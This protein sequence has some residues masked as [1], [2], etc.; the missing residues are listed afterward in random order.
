[1][2]FPFLGSL[3]L[4]QQTA[5]HLTG[6]FYP[7]TTI[8]VCELEYPHLFTCIQNRVSLNHVFLNLGQY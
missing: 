1:M 4:L 2:L 7:L 6:M 5:M 8:S 3:V